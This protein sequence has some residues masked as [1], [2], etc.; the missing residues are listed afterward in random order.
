MMVRALTRTLFILA[1]LIAIPFVVAWSLANA[2]G[3][4]R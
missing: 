4:R 3:D 1:A 2:N